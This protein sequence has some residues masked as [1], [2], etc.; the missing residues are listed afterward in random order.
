MPPLSPDHSVSTMPL[1]VLI[2]TDPGLD[3]ALAL[4]L[5]C[6]SPELEVAGVVTVAGN[7]GLTRVTE[8]ALRLL[9]H[10]GRGEIPVVAGAADPLTR[11][12]L[13][14]AEIHG[15]DGLGGV[16]LAP[17][18]RAA[19]AEDAI[20]FMEDELRRRAERSLRILALG[21]LTNVARFIQS[22]P[23]AASRLERVV[24]MGG[25]VRD[26][27]N[28]TPF[29]EFNIAADPQAADVVLRSGIPF[30]LVPLDVTR[31]VTADAAFCA[32]LRAADRGVAATS[33]ALIEAYLA[34]LATRRKAKGLATD[35]H[36]LVFPL[37]DPCVV[38]H[39]IDPGLFGSERLPISIVTDGSECEGQT[40]I[41]DE[42][43]IEIEVLTQAKPDAIELAFDL[44]RSL[45]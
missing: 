25:A 5:A 45:P 12:P 37:H 44:L 22:R 2:D 27:G 9:A 43:G 39:V 29:A 31:K 6:A 16:A 21:P 17:S 19:L 24:A 18:P 32:R 38:L 36:P 7:I 26:A 8:N 15:D 35:A 40:V 10:A 33:A 28:V 14:A 1:S 34:N 13:T 20:E 11:A 30:T 42:R 41:D 23:S 3:D 4:F